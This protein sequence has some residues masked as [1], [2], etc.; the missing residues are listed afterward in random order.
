MSL[1]NLLP[2]ETKDEAW[3]KLY[4]NELNA[5]GLTSSL[6]ELGISPNTYTMP[7]P[8]VSIDPRSV[9]I[10]VDGSST[11]FRL[12]RRVD[13]SF[14]GIANANPRYLAY[15]GTTDAVAGGIINYLTDFRAP[16]TMRLLQLSIVSANNDTTTSW[17][18]HNNNG[19]VHTFTFPANGVYNVPGGLLWVAGERLTIGWLGVGTQPNNTTI[20]CFFEQS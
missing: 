6:A 12:L 8:L 18:I 11:E 9:L 20:T 19:I 14:G 5:Q 2:S 15:N 17:N 4:A 16:F 1:S 10:N 7:A 13:V 3:S